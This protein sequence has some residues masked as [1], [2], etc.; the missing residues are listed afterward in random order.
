MVFEAVDA[1]QLGQMRRK[2]SDCE[3]ALEIWNATNPLPPVL[4]PDYDYGDGTAGQQQQQHDADADAEAQAEEDE[5]EDEDEE[6]EE[7][8]EGVPPPS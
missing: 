5:D 3:E 1:K 7:V 8:E 4:P 6:E 2:F